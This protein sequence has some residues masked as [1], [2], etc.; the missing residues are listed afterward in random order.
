MLESKNAVITGTNRGL[1]RTLLETFAK[2]GANVFACVRNIDENFLK[3]CS[4]LANLY[5]VKIKPLPFDLTDEQAMKAAVKLIKDEKCNVDILVNN[6]GVV[7]EN[8]LFNMASE[9][10]MYRVFEINFFAAMRLTKLISKLMIR[11]KFGS[12]VNITSIS[13]FDGEPGQIEYVSSKAAL[14]G[15]TKKLASELGNFNI[16]VNAVAAGVINT[17]VSASMEEKLKESVINRTV[18]KRL[19]KP[20]EV[21]DVTAFLASDLSSYM[22]GQ[23]LRVDG[24]L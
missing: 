12:I 11:Q 15:A 18:M 7:P 6:A 9:T 8:R 20:E 5:G 19:G 13:A 21:A 17:G 10:E 2:Y 23:V 3:T 1:G 4:D 14:I 16:R 22:T 24:G